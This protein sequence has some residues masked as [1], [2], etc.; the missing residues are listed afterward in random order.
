MAGMRGPNAETVDDY[1][2]ALPQNQRRALESLRRTIKS[3]A[4]KA[5]EGISYQI[6]TYKHQGMLVSF[7]AFKNH[8]SLFGATSD[9]RRQFAKQ[10]KDFEQSAGTIRFTPEKPLPAALVKRIVRARVA[11]NE[12]RAKR[13]KS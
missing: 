4:P 11:E 2:A 3:A 12:A 1:L 8:L 7:A 9:L 10:L 13:R 6:P 5:T